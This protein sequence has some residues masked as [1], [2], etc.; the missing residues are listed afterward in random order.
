MLG[1]TQSILNIKLLKL[2][3]MTNPQIKKLLIQVME[4]DKKEKIVL[5]ED[6]MRAKRL[7]FGMGENEHQAA[8]LNPVTEFD[9]LYDLT[10]NELE[11]IGAVLEM[12]ANKLM[13]AYM[14]V[15]NQINNL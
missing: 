5:I 13:A 8:V 7:L 4:D 9:R 2:K 14:G 15:I 1:P 6:I 12:K 10:I 11:I 3:T